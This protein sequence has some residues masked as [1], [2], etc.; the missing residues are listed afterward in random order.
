[1]DGEM[2]NVGSKCILDDD[3]DDEDDDDDSDD[4]DEEE[5]DVIWRDINK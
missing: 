1:M 5:G 4:G 3:D 2:V